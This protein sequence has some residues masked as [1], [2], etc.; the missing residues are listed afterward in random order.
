MTEPQWLQAMPIIKNPYAFLS[1][2][3]SA[4]DSLHGTF[5]CVQKILVERKGFLLLQRRIFDIPVY[6]PG[7]SFAQ[8]KMAAGY[9][10]YKKSVCISLGTAFGVGFPEKR[11]HIEQEV[12]K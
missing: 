5:D 1:A 2:Q 8:N 3:L 10:D 11:K 7:Q 6:M 9:A 12:A 4:W